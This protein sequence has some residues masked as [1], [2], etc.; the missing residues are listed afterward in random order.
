[1]HGM[2]SKRRW[3]VCAQATTIAGTMLALVGCQSSSLDD[4]ENVRIWATTASAVAVFAEVYD[5]IAFADG[6]R[7]FDDPA[8]PHTSDDG[9]TATVSGECTDCSGATW[10]GS[11]TV[12]R[13]V[14]GDRHLTLD[15]FSHFQG[16]DMRSTMTGTALVHSTGATTHDFSVDLEKR[17]GMTTRFHYRGKVEGDYD[18][19]T[20]WSGT[21]RIERD[22]VL[23][24]TGTIDATTVDERVDNAVCSGQP[25]SGQT[26]IVAD[27]DT[28]VVSYDGATDCDDAHAAR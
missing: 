19:P 16:A 10:T 22:G 18:A 14:D 8:C 11:A 13:T 15:A 4:A 26:T 24:P 27:G 2:T 20:I 9:T 3:G 7:T 1:M 21:G 28:A 6:H 25:V 23:A 12:T 17:G 5:P